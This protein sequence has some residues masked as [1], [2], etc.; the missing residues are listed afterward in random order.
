MF[1]DYFWL[2][3]RQLGL[4]TLSCHVQGWNKQLLKRCI[5]FSDGQVSISGLLYFKIDDFQEMSIHVPEIDLEH[6]PVLAPKHSKKTWF[7]PYGHGHVPVAV[8]VVVAAAAAV[9]VVVAGSIPFTYCWY[10]SCPLLNRDLWRTIYL[11]WTSIGQDGR[12]PI[13]GHVQ[14]PKTVT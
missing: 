12:F 4:S 10:Q 14:K 13:W 6:G 3:V 9:V 7:E 2:V 1:S 8:T 5:Q 11:A